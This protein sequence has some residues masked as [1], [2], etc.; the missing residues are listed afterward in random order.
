MFPWPFRLGLK[1]GRSPWTKPFHFPRAASFCLI[2]TVDLP[3]DVETT[4]TITR[5]DTTGFV[6]LDALQLL[7]VK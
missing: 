3:V 7:L 1:N 4:I 2:D 5:T 6:V